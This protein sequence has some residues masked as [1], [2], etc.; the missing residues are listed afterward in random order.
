MAKHYMQFPGVYKQDLLQPGTP[1]YCL[2]PLS[3]DAAQTMPRPY[4]ELFHVLGPWGK[5]RR[6]GTSVLPTQFGSQR[7][8]DLC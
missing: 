6:H 2:G 1:D 7:Y 5:G 8:S 4:F 3:L